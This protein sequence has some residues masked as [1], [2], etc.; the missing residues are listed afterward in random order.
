MHM[1]PLCQELTSDQEKLP[2]NKKWNHFRGKLSFFQQLITWLHIICECVSLL[3]NIINPWCMFFTQQSI[4]CRVNYAQNISESM[5]KVSHQLQLF[6]SWPFPEE[7]QRVLVLLEYWC[8]WSTGVT[9]VLVLLEYWCILEMQ[10]S[11][12]YEAAAS[13]REPGNLPPTSLTAFV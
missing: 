6:P 3:S 2:R 9:G 12:K 8:C 5:S 4:H 10:Q 1:T 13:Q 11:G 7:I